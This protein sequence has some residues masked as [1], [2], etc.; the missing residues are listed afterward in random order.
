MAR[1]RAS[2][3]SPRSSSASHRAQRS[4]LSYTDQRATRAEGRDATRRSRG[5]SSTSTAAPA[6]AAAAR[7]M[8]CSGTSA[9]LLLLL[10]PLPPPGELR[11]LP[12]AWR[13]AV[14]TGEG[15]RWGRGRVRDAP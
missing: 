4:L 8:A 13:G 1:L 5:P 11:F 10:L 14:I 15:A 12:P 9:L 7:I 2:S 3:R 6:L